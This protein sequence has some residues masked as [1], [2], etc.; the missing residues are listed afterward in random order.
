MEEDYADD[1]FAASSAFGPPE[2]LEDALAQGLALPTIEEAESALLRE[3]LRRFDGNR[4]QTAEAL[5]ISER[6]LYRK[7][8]DIEGDDDED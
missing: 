7:V 5:G 3:A 8:K 6:T 1:G 4:R 2:T